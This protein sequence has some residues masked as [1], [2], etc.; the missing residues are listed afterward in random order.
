MIVAT[1]A[2]GLVSAGE[3]DLDPSSFLRARKSRKFMG[4]QDD[5]A[6]ITAGRALAQA[7]L[8][9]E[10]LGER[11]GLFAVI[12]YIPFD[13]SDI[14]P[15]LAASLE[16]ERFSMQRFSNGGFQQAH[17]LLT[18]R[19]LPNMPA[20]HVS[21][22]FDVRGPYYVTYPGAGQVYAALEE[23]STALGEGLIDVA[24]V[25]AVAHQRNF[26]VEHHLSRVDPPVP[27][28][29]LRD[30]GGCL[31]L[32]RE[33]SAR[34]AGRKAVL[35]LLEMEQRYRSYAPIEEQRGEVETFSGRAHASEE[36]RGPAA[37]FCELADAVSSQKPL[38]VEHRLSARDGIDAFSTWQVHP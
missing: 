8:S 9:R 24:L 6:V 29:A 33:E 27:S 3:V 38:R 17:P 4:I 5:L 25:F 16:G 19:C 35:A 14:A 10:L 23:A 30:A 31:V 15:V 18:F 26:L 13:K 36:Y 34:T 28:A 22:N 1:G 21:A 11:A 32:E 2:A 37:L 12:G 7:R 20:Y